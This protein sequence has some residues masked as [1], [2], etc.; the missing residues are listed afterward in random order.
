MASTIANRTNMLGNYLKIAFRTLW[1]SRGFSLI[2]ILGLSVGL[3]ACFLIFLYVRLEY[4]YDEFHSKAGRIYRVVTD[5]KTPTSTDH[6]AGTTGPIAINVKKDMPEVEDA[7]RLTGD[8]FLVRKGDFKFQE[9][10]V[11]L[12]DSTLFHIFDF[13]LIEGDRRTALVHPMSIVIS[14]TAA[15]KYFGDAD[16]LGQQ[17][18]LTAAAIP[19]TI[20]GVMKDIPE[21]SQIPA[22]MFI[23]MSSAKP[24]YGRPSSDSEWTNHNY[25]SYLL[26]NPRAVAASV[27]KKLPAFMELHDGAQMRRLQMY[28]T[29]TLEPLRDVY[30]KSPREGYVKG[31]ITN[32]RIFSIVAIFILLIACVN[33]V[34]LTTARST[35]RAKEVGVRKVIGAARSQ[36]FRQ[37]TLESV[38]I[39]LLAFVVSLTLIRL[40]LPLFNEMAGKTISPG[41]LAHPQDLLLLFVLSLGIG[42]LA[43][44]YPSLV[45]SSF[46]PVVVLKGRFS[47]GTRGVFLRKSLVVFQFT[48]S[49]ALIVST[50]VVY[51]QLD[52]MR[53]QDL[54]F[55]KDQQMV[56][57]TNF[58][59]KRYAFAQSLSGIP[60]VLST[61]FSSEAPGQGPTSAYSQ[62]ENA[63]GQMQKMNID[64]SFTDF[65]YIPQYQLKVVAGRAF[66][67]DFQTDS[68]RAMIINETA[69]KMLG[70]TSPAAAVGRRF[71]QWERQGQII[72]VLKDFHYRSL[73][74]EI[75]PLAMRIE[76]WALGTI[77]IKVSAK[78][79]PATIAAIHDK[80][81]QAIPNRPFEYSFLDEDFNKHYVSEV[82]F[83]RLFINF[84]VLAIFISCLGL[85][86]LAAYSTT[87][88]TKEIGVRKVLGASVASITRLLSAD[89]VWL[90]FIAFLIASPIAWLAM[91]SWLHNFAYRTAIGWW[92]FA[93]AGFTALFIVILTISWQAI[94]AAVQNPIKSLR[95]E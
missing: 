95:T 11:L 47:A 20:T 28:E 38:L 71:D 6:E 57:F 45:L 5:I 91:N 59:D 51:T 62:L 26:L 84:S 36:L 33:F 50:I 69:A 92:V 44:I 4:S 23:S 88:R 16:P 34:N 68:G 30:L 10:K 66:S 12:A 86:G 58:D 13:P 87:Q 24:I 15:K 65:D 74:Q 1:A 94:R 70:Y 41:L 48:I 32:V 82:R 90:V 46:R 3:S 83:G 64:L 56:I 37:F 17:L 31:S 25:I 93:L 9:K 63:N 76:R 29:L 19:A 40:A 55:S 21:N 54:G 7:V 73:Q 2:N 89:F 43:G 8:Q 75:R 39:T 60:G 61:C 14:Q 85:L 42:L 22:D 53:S 80:W 35:Q 18:Q 79:L 67:H 78:H 81:A 52:Y 49:I 77:S 72:G 27:E